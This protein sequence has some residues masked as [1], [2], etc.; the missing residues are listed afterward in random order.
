MNRAPANVRPSSSPALGSNDDAR[1]RLHAE[2][3]RHT[4]LSRSPPA[5][6]A[7]FFNSLLGVHR[8]CN[9]SGWPSGTL[10]R[11]GAAV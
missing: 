11:C 4:Q 5:P 3:Q 2:Y 1:E 10:K 8:Y 7:Y 6:S 9:T